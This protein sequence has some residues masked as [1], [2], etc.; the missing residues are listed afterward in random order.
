MDGAKEARDIIES[1]D[2]W[3][4][5]ADILKVQEPLV[6]VLRPV[7]GD[8]KPTMGYIYE[9]MDRAKMAIQKDC[10][11]YAEYWKIIDHRWAFQLHTDLHAAGKQFYT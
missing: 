7:D 2:F 11:Y 1:K 9:A 10:R 4:K 6:K 5:A 3:A 8:L